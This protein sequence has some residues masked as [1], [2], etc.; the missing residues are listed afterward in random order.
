MNDSIKLRFNGDN[1]WRATISE[2]PTPIYAF[3]KMRASIN[4]LKVAVLVTDHDGQQFTA[5]LG[6]NFHLIN[7][8]DRRWTL[9]GEIYEIQ[10]STADL[11]PGGVLFDRVKFAFKAA[12]EM[13]VQLNYHE[14]ILLHKHSDFLEGA[15]DWSAIL[16]DRNVPATMT[17]Y[18]RNLKGKPVEVTGY[19]SELGLTRVGDEVNCFYIY[20]WVSDRRES[21]YIKEADILKILKFVHV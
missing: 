17:A 2:S 16:F 19:F 7:P 10:I 9:P 1:G 20:D 8:E 11:L 15:G 3:M 18:Y 4:D 13:L 6:D 21:L 12:G 14:V 5:H